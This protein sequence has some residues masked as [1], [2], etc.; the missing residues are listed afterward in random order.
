[1]S[2]KA[3]KRVVKGD[4]FGV[5]I[6]DGRFAYARECFGACICVYDA[7]TPTLVKSF[8]LNKVKVIFWDGFFWSGG[9]RNGDWPIVLRQPLTEEDGWGPPTR[10]MATRK[11]GM[12]GVSFKG[13]SVLVR[14][15]E[16]MDMEYS[17]AVSPQGLINKIHKRMGE[18]RSALADS[19]ELETAARHS[20]ERR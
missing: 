2:K 18:F 10:E 12:R 7:I 4:V 9:V 20:S 8:D 11:G 13:R 14:D 19:I 16:T 3:P 17:G 5:P 6:G 1:M 15:E